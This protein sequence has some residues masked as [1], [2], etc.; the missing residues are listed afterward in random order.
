MKIYSSLDTP[1]LPHA[2][3]L[4]TLTTE[5]FCIDVDPIDQ[6]A[7][8]AVAEVAPM[9][10]LSIAR[11]DSNGAVVTRKSE[12]SQDKTGKRYSVIIAV[13]GDVMISHHLGLSELKSGD[14]ILMDNAYPRTL[15]VYN[16]V[17]LLIVSVPVQ[18]LQRFI[19]VPED[20]EGQKLS[21]G[22]AGEGDPT[23][24]YEPL[25]TLWDTIKKGQL[26][27]FAAVLSDNFLGS[28]STQYSQC[29]PQE[30]GR[31][32]K[33]ITQTKQLIEEQLGNPELTVELLAQLLGV[34]SRYLR[35]LFSRSEKISHYILR[36]RLEE[37]ANQLANA[38]H[39][40]ISITSI[41]FQ[42]GFNSTAH[43]S[44]AFRKQYGVSAREYRRQHQSG[45]AA[46]E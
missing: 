30:S 36:R 17:S 18:V 19:P 43:F 2:N 39:Q 45:R 29:F 4:Y 20:V 3:H 16:Q 40:N 35:A 37:C 33:R 44:R 23:P 21:A 22:N 11:I 32:A 14:F 46:S 9:G 8:R 41:A 25:I 7:Y 13:Q 34:S 26:K 10:P 38:L 12:S 27:E 31:A 15:F 28:L 24:F 1:A 5:N 42:C 6:Q